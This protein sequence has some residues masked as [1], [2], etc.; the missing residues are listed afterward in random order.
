MKK[1]RKLVKVVREID[2]SEKINRK[3]K[4]LED[5]RNEVNMKIKKYCE[6]KGFVFI[7]NDNISESGLNNSK[8][9]LLK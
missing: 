1:V 6:G 7:E 5:E 9:H 3:D 4:H 2:N 8:L